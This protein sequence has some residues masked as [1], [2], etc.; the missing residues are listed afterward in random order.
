[1]TRSLRLA[2][3][4]AEMAGETAA[5]I[6][7]RAALA[8]ARATG[9]AG[10]KGTASERAGHRSS[11]RIRMFDGMSGA[12]I[13]RCLPANQRAEI[14]AMLGVKKA[15][16]AAASAAPAAKPKTEVEA[17]AEI[18]AAIAESR[19]EKPIAP[20][21]ATSV[22]TVTPAVTAAPKKLDAQAIWDKAISANNHGCS[23]GEN[24]ASTATTKAKASP[25]I[26]DRAIAANWPTGTL[27][28]FA[29]QENHA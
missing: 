29:K 3:H 25:N 18:R 24:A 6:G 20:A 11:S 13:A 17:R 14:G 2:A 1:M 10:T 23:L 28:N 5:A 22:R 27:P 8:R 7:L 21:Q 4:Q 19:G 12:E 16:P 26:W 15:G 9:P